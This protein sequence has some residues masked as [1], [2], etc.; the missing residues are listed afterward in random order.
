MSS[1]M[2]D[3]EELQVIGAFLWRPDL[4]PAL[5]DIETGHF[6][7]PKHGWVWEAGR[8]LEAL[9]PTSVEPISLDDLRIEIA[10]TDQ[11]KGTFAL[12]ALE[13]TRV[14]DRLQ[15]QRELCEGA[16]AELIEIDAGR[17][18]AR[19]AGPRPPPPPWKFGPDLVPLITAR[20]KDPFV[21]L[22]LGAD[23]LDEVR[24]GGIVL[25]TGGTGSG[26]TSL[27]ATL[28]VQHARDIGPAIAMSLELPADEIGARIVGIQCDASWKQV[29]TGGVREDFMLQALPE[30]L[31]VI[32]R[33]DASMKNL[34]D[35]IAVMRARFGDLPILVAVDY[36]QIMDND[37][38]EIRRRVAVA[39]AQLDD[40]ARE[41]RVVLL[42]VSQGSRASSNA[43]KSGEKLGAQTTDAGAE[44][45]ELERWSTLTIAIGGHVP[46]GDDTALVQIS[47]GK[48]RMGVGDVVRMARYC[49]RS[50]RWRLEGDARPAADVRAERETSN[51]SARVNA[52]ALAIPAALD[53]E[54]E[55]LSRREL[56]KVLAAQDKLVRAAVA[57]VLADPDSDVV[58]VGP[59]VGGAWQLWTRRRA[60]AAGR[61]IKPSGGL[62]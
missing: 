55:P 47:I 7:N 3:H 54:P 26:K 4:R 38:R 29:L 50:G 51:A 19:A 25:E 8:N 39:M 62:P 61:P 33:R 35:L 53:R 5:E 41:M 58:E 60:T 13:R 6:A 21:E 14:L 48:S 52:L 46:A 17:L 18:R 45:A 31:A 59:K 22:K 20:A 10:R 56:N 32:E 24:L 16:P 28:L 9:K 15:A 49:G 30:R 12:E 27:A 23:V 2:A 34:R 57:A 44:A 43:L 11:E 36:V 42:V 40:L 37:E 1:V